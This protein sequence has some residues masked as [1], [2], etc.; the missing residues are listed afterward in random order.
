MYRETISIAANHSQ[1][2][3]TMLEEAGEDYI[4][5]YK[6]VWQT[7][8]MGSA[9]QSSLQD[10][11]ALRHARTLIKEAYQKL[12]IDRTLDVL[13]MPNAPTT[14]TEHDTWLTTTFT[15]LWNV[16]D[17]PAITIPTG[18]VTTGDLADDIGNAAFGELDEKNYRMCK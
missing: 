15:L 10:Y 13:V 9:P 6:R 11:W 17:Y 14:A 7:D 12:W 1:S 18:K 5:S 16:L 8:G 2:M 3:K 4:A